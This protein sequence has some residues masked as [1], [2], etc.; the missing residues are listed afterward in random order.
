MQFIPSPDG[1]VAFNDTVYSKL[2]AIKSKVEAVRA[3]WY[4]GV[5]SVLMPIGEDIATIGPNAEIVDT[6]LNLG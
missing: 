2:K 6:G 3:M 1:P 5:P 4:L